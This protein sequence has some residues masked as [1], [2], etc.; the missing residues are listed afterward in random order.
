MGRKNLR[1]DYSLWRIH[2]ILSHLNFSFVQIAEFWVFKKSTPADMKIYNH[3][4]NQKAKVYWC[5]K[6]ELT[7]GSLTLKYSQNIMS[8]LNF[9]FIQCKLRNFGWFYHLIDTPPRSQRRTGR[10]KKQTISFF[11][12]VTVV[13]DDPVQFWRL[14][15]KLEQISP[16]M[17]SPQQTD[18]SESSSSQISPN[19]PPHRFHRFDQM[20]PLLYTY[21][22]ITVILSS[23][24]QFFQFLSLSSWKA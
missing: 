24:S 21:R 14:L 9:S 23:P 17:A 4:I 20:W 11:S 19:F 15:Q 13:H 16:N 6:K 22:Q 3:I 10:Y 7:R 5:R 1:E 8:R 2:R 12:I 18:N